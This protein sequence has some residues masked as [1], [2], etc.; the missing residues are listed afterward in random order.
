MTFSVI[1]LIELALIL[2][3]IRH[4]VRMQEK[5]D[6]L[7]GRLSRS[8]DHLKETRGFIGLM[9]AALKEAGRHE[10]VLRV[11]AEM[12]RRQMLRLKTLLDDAMDRIS[13]LV[14]E[15]DALHHELVETKADL[16]DAERRAA[17]DALT[18]L[19]N[20][21]SFEERFSQWANHAQRRHGTLPTPFSMLMVDIDFFK[22][23]NDTYGHPAG[24]KVLAAVA[25]AIRGCLRADDIPARYGGE[26]FAIILPDTEHPRGL[27]V[28]GRILKAIEK[29]RVS[30]EDGR[31]ISVT[32][33]IGFG[34]HELKQKESAAKVLSAETK[35]VDAALYHAKEQGRNRI[36]PATIL[37]VE[38]PSS[39]PAT[40]A[41][42]KAVK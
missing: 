7:I 14:R 40:P 21:R 36:V 38:R 30:L 32:A 24:D 1:V 26:E 11:K 27:H 28:A 39:V 23:I 9:K 2:A 31:R 29:L 33:S 19:P 34:S 25:K 37:P 8:E 17:T 3:L 18:E 20:R 4:T 5:R 6:G 42:L 41:K 16:E 22:R 13:E 15:H 35:R 12:Y 10:E